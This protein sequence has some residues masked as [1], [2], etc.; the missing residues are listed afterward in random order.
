MLPNP[1]SVVQDIPDE[2]ITPPPITRIIEASDQSIDI[3]GEIKVDESG[4]IL[5]EYLAIDGFSTPVISAYDQWIKDGIPRQLEMYPIMTPSGRRVMFQLSGLDEKFPDERVPGFKKPRDRLG[6]LYPQRARDNDL[7][8]ASQ[9]TVDL[10]LERQGE[11]GVWQEEKRLPNCTFGLIP[12]MLGS[13]LCHLRG[14]TD[15][16]RLE[17]GECSKDPLGYFIVK[18][19]ERIVII[20]E[21]LRKN[22]IFLFNN[23]KRTTKP[24]VKTKAEE[25]KEVKIVKKKA[26][27]TNVVCQMTCDTLK[28]PTAS[29]SL[30][31]IIRYYSD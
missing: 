26:S 16:E 21:K 1:R 4:R 23:P 29:V 19:A 17:L 14:K 9:M 27:K 12:T 13:S 3:P 7:T 6:P 24:G 10:V 25:G 30:S 22:R 11:A 20:Q 28:G 15:V 8:Y 18:G 2:L 5:K 31:R